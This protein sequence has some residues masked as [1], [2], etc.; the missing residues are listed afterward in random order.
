MKR[1]GFPDLAVRAAGILAVIAVAASNAAAE[2]CP[3]APDHSTDLN[4]LIAQVQAAESEDAARRISNRMWEYWADAPDDQAQ[5]MLDRGMSRRASFDLLG[6]LEDF[7]RLIAYCPHYAEGF[8]QRAFVNFLRQDYRT[9]LEDLDRA[10]ELSPDH[11]AALSGR[12]LSLFALRRMDEARD[13]LSEA[14]ALNPWL[15]ERSLAAPGGP[16]EPV[17]EDL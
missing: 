14:L 13:A 17:G 1:A 12:A 10:L 8:N 4:A 7:D 9:A 15:P 6:A 16:L 11:V 2:T 3:A 5:A